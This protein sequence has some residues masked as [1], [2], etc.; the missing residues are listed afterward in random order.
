[1]LVFLILL[2]RASDRCIDEKR[3][4]I[5]GDDILFALSTLGFDNYVHPL[6]SYLK[7]YREVCLIVELT[8]CRV[9]KMFVSEFVFTLLI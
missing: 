9:L 6:Q 3:K 8:I 1:M 2:F 5:T 7:K 4:T